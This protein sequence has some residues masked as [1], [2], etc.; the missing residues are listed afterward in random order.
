MAYGKEI[1]EIRDRL[2]TLTAIEGHKQVT[3]KEYSYDADGDVSTVK[4]YCGDE[5]LL[6]L[7]FKY[8]ASKNLISIERG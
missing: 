7:L 4:F 2:A 8:D 5:L 3:K 6:T 1:S